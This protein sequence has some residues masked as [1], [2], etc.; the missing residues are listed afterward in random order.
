MKV[1]VAL[2][3]FSALMSLTVSVDNTE[4][5]S[6]FVPNMS[7]DIRGHEALHHHHHHL[8]H[9]HPSSISGRKATLNLNPISSLALEAN[10]QSDP[11]HAQAAKKDSPTAG[12]ENCFWFSIF[13]RREV[14]PAG[15]ATRSLL[16]PPP[17]SPKSPQPFPSPIPAPTTQP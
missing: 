15:M 17:P 16:P 2:L 13:P 11:A 3:G 10:R 1:E 6:Q 9:H 7:T 8:H 4:P 5:W 14:S 12:V